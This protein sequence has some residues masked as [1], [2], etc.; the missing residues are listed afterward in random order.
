[1]TGTVRVNLQKT[2]I[3]SAYCFYHI[4]TDT[5]ENVNNPSDHLFGTNMC[6]ERTYHNKLTSVKSI[7]DYSL[8]LTVLVTTIDALRHFETG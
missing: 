7:F 6:E 1:M 8:T 3:M 4:M 2:V 5:G